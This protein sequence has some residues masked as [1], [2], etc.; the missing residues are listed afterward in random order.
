MKPVS[1]FLLAVCLLAGQAQYLAARTFDFMQSHPAQLPGH[2]GYSI[3]AQAQGHSSHALPAHHGSHAGHVHQAHGHV[4]H[5][6]QGR[7]SNAYQHQ[8]GHGHQHNRH[9]HFAVTPSATTPV[10]SK[11]NPALMCRVVKVPVDTTV[12]AAPLTSHSGSYGVGSHIATSIGK[13]NPV[14][15]LLQNASATSLQN[16]S[17]PHTV[18]I[19]KKLAVITKFGHQPMTTASVPARPSVLTDATT[20]PSLEM[21]V[22]STGV[23]KATTRSRPTTKISTLAPVVVSTLGAPASTLGVPTPLADTFPVQAT[24]IASTDIPASVQQEVSSTTRVAVRLNTGVDSTP[25]VS[26]SPL[27]ITAAPSETSAR[28]SVSTMAFTNAVATTATALGSLDPRAA[29][30]TALVTSTDEYTFGPVHREQAN[31]AT[32]TPAGTKS[33]TPLFVESNAGTVPTSAP[34]Q[35]GASPAT[36]G[37]VSVRSA[38]F[39]SAPPFAA[40]PTIPGTE[41]P[42]TATTAEGITVATTTDSAVTLPAMALS[43]TSEPASSKPGKSTVIY[44]RSARPKTR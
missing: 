5:Q 11:A 19:Q 43:A 41:A 38:R 28:G 31:T 36:V 9:H 30:F 15:A 1:L 12:P 27:P 21:A 4:V 37:A 24:T 2:H 7:F 39:T 13:V 40:A 14:M 6:G 17:V 8:V 34:K 25:L 3:S 10:A 29:P 33:P 20:A 22:P 44:A 42:P 32:V 18:V 16:T 26:Q 35:L 23:A